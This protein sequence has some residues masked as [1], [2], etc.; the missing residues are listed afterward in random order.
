ME[1]LTSI[2]NLILAFL[3]NLVN[4]E[5]IGAL[6]WLIFLVAVTLMFIK[7]VRGICK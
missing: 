4:D 1:F 7:F 5:K 6:I 3:G 2:F